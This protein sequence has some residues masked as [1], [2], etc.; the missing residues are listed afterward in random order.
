MKNLLLAIALSRPR[1]VMAVTALLTVG[2]ALLTL[3]IQVDT[4]PENM[5]PADEPSRIHHEEVKEAFGLHDYLVVGIVREEPGGVFRPETL[6]RVNE[7][8]DGILELDGVI[9]DDVIAPSQVDDVFT[10]GGILRVA[11]LM[12]EA[13][14]TD[15]G[16]QLVL[17][18]IRANPF[19]RGRLASDDG[20]AMALFIPI[21]SKDRAHEVAGEVQ[22]LIDN[23]GGDEDYH[24][25]GIPLAEDRFGS[26]MF[27]QMATGGPAAFLLIFILM[28]V[29]FR[30]VRLVLGPMILSAVTVIWTMGALI[31]LG[32][33]VHIMS[34]MIPVFLIPIAVLNSIH[35]LSEFHERYPRSHDRKQALRETVHQL[36]SPM[37]YTS[38][39]T[40]VGF[41][42]LMLTPIPPVQVFGAAVSFGI[43]IAWL[44]S[45]TFLMAYA[46]LVP[47]KSLENFGSAAGGSKALIRAVA[48]TERLAVRHAKPVMTFGVLVFVVSIIGL[49]RIQVN[50]NPV[51]WFRPG[52]PLRVADAVMN[53]HL[54]GTYLAYLS[55][56]ADEPDAFKDP[57]TMHWVEGLQKHLETDPNVG[58][59]LSI[60]DIVKKVRSELLGSAD[61]AVIP[62][63]SDEI[64]QEIFLYEISGGDP[65]DLF[66]IISPETDHANV[67]IQMYAGEN[68]EVA[69]VVHDTDEYLRTAPPGIHATWAGLPYIN[70]VWQDK[71]VNGMGKALAGSGLTV[72]LMMVW[73]FRSFRLGLLSMVP[74]TATIV[75]VYGMIGWVGKAYDMPIAV[76]SSLTLGLSIDFAIHFLERAREAYDKTGNIRETLDIVFGPPARAIA[77]NVIVV[78]LAFVPMFFASLVPYVTVALFFFAIMMVSGFA[79]MISLPSILLLTGGKFLKTGGNTMKKSTAAAAAAVVVGGLMILGGADRA[80]AAPDANALMKESHLA[81][82]YAGDDGQVTVGMELTDKRGRTRVRR[83]QMLRMDETDGGAQK[84]FTY[85][86]E[87]SDVRRTTFMVWKDPEAEDAR[88]IY[89]PAVDLVKRIS[90]KDKGSSFMGSDFSYEDVSGR[91]WTEDNH[92]YLGEETLDGK[93]CD[94]IQSVPKEEDSFTKK[95]SWIDRETKLPLKEEYYDKK[96]RLERVFTSDSIETIDGFPT[97][98]VR[99]MANVLKD[100]HTTVTFENIKYNVGVDTDLFTERK[101]K[102]PPTSLMGGN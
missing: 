95:I 26:E 74:L 63:T 35:L 62:E 102:S 94:R 52:H 5:L 28:V 64:A 6:A 96:D 86:F 50:D 80:A 29:F 70:I 67:W 15:E 3:R 82:Y 77:R 12:E 9:T 83:F 73:L 91:K 19:L 27:L 33:T 22:V 25:G 45:L 53:Q 101:L 60:V 4:D 46:S 23:L 21:E 44:L 85:F 98:T 56:K 99:S 40:V 30:N 88:W 13:P 61:E 38:I 54:N 36:F 39:T 93:V 78:A 71:M 76:L 51:K 8:T 90:S 65:E 24:L 92:T 79:T 34:S 18:R 59:T 1:T 55:L 72:F 69:R 32:F 20:A 11:T 89:V 49:M 97:A 47:V 58:S 75:L 37:T 100:H 42:S 7:L 41:A 16:A 43:A 10:E 2:F 87:P 14:E 81:M 48:V 66:K 31:G 84:Y 68:R 57:E 17:E